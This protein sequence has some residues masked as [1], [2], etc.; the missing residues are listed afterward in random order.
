MV[1]SLE[2]FEKSDPILTQMKI[3]VDFIKTPDR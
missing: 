2:D 3:V 1:Q